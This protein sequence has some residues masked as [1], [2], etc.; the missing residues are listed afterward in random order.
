MDRF[1]RG[2]VPCYKIAPR[3]SWRSTSR[4]SYNDLDDV[5]DIE[6]DSI[7]SSYEISIRFTSS[8]GTYSLSI[9]SQDGEYS[10]IVEDCLDPGDPQSSPFGED[11]ACRK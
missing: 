1:T 3:A 4:S 2:R 10:Y 5:E 11:G 9:V 7:P 6:P 8:P